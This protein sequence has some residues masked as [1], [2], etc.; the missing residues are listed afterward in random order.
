MMCYNANSGFRLNFESEPRQAAR[1]SN[2]LFFR[3]DGSLKRLILFVSVLLLGLLPFSTATPVPGEPVRLTEEKEGF[4]YPL[5]SPDGRFMAMTREDWTGIW[6]MNS[7]ATQLEELTD[8]RGAGYKFAWSPD[9]RHIAYRAEKMIDGQRHFAIR[10]VA[11]ETGHIEEMTDFERFLGTPRWVLGDGTVVFETDRKGTLAQAQVAGLISLMDT[12]KSVNLVATTSRDLRIWVSD[13]YGDDK[14]LLSDP[15]ERCFDP[16]LSPSGDRVCYSVLANGG[17]IAV[18][19]T[20]GSARINLGYG[21]DP[22]WSPDDQYLVYEV[23]ADDGMVITGSDLYLI[24]HDG[25][26]RVQL[27]DTPNL[28][29][30]WPSWSPDGNKIA[31][32]AGGA[33]YVMP[34]PTT[35]ISTE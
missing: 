27:T 11:V 10:L 18:A 2:H 19:K 8:D 32:S 20:D 28:F 34:I 12:E 22:C 29:E 33:I 21:S 25:T 15:E 9:S 30:R 4:I 13:P 3:K 23:T 7:D 6:R 5:W 31:F 26:G 35:I 1:E 16:I 14:I 17:S 24:E